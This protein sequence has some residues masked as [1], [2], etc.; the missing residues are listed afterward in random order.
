MVL[1]GFEESHRNEHKPNMLSIISNEF[2]HIE[3]SELGPKFWK[4][5]T[6]SVSG[7]SVKIIADDNSM[8]IPDV[9]KTNSDG[10]A[11]FSLTAFE[12]PTSL[13]T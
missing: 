3:K 2:V 6:E 12:G 10:S 4:D 11:I 5:T 1:S 7:T 13:L 8:V 9:I